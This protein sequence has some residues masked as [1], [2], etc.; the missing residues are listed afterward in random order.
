MELKVQVKQ[1]GRRE[2][3]IVTAKLL[4]KQTPKT[5]GELIASAVKAAYAAHYEK[6]SEIEAFENGDLSRV[7]I[8]TQD[9]LEQKAS[10]GKIDFGFLK[11]D[12]KV[13][14]KE[15]V[16]TALQAFDD[17]LVAVF[18]DGTRYENTDDALEL[19]GD[20]TVTFVKL[21]MLTGRLW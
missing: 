14:E 9:E 17:G 13:S 10:G 2:N 8:Y 18:V 12:K 6:A 15:A 4:L 7:I 1:A 19:T 3:K 11:N 20:E 16:E 5:A 21:T